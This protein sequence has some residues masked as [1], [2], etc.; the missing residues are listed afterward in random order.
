MSVFESNSSTSVGL[1]SSATPLTRT[2]PQNIRIHPRK[3]PTPV[4]V[5][6]HPLF[7]GTY[8][9]E[10]PGGQLLLIRYGTPPAGHYFLEEAWKFLKSIGYKQSPDDPALFKSKDSNHYYT[11]ICLNIEDFMVGATRRTRIDKLF[12]ELQRK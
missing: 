4:F 8:K 7:D 6:Q 5:Q 3:I 10:E 2:F 12:S 1:K 9:H 11:K